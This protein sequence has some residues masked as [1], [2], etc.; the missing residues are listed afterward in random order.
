MQLSSGKSWKDEN[1]RMT[2][3][4]IVQ[5][6]LMK[7]FKDANSKLQEKGLGSE[8]FEREN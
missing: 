2:T 7:N 5:C 4:H 6:F 8:M 3:G 1:Q